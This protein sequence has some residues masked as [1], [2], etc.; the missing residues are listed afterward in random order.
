MDAVS[1]L[2]QTD[3]DAVP[4]HNRPGDSQIKATSIVAVYFLPTHERL[5]DIRDITTVTHKP[6]KPWR[7]FELWLE[8][9][10]GGEVHA[11]LELSA[12]DSALMRCSQRLC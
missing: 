5:W 3:V 1:L 11:E 12:D 4:L 10:T 7:L 8:T 6:L 2:L 9:G